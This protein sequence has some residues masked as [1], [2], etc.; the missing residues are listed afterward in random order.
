METQYK[1]RPANDDD[2]NKIYALIRENIAT[3]K[4]IM[5]PDL[6]PEGFME[7]FVD[8]LIRKGSMLVVENSFLEMELIG[9]VHDYQTI[10]QPDHE[11]SE[12]KE[13]SFYSRLDKMPGERETT[14]VNWLFGEI[15]TNY[16][17]VFRVELN[18]PITN[19]ASIEF[20]KSLGL[21]IEGNYNGRLKNKPEH[22]HLSLPLSWI[23]HS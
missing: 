16:R 3:D 9:E 18:T 19:S 14:L 5:S 4:K 22:L 11:E 2:K 6:I 23:N 21:R 20:Y 13:L 8:K 7:E 17:D 12:M 10:E 1:I 15:R